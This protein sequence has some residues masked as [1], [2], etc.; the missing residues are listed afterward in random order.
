MTAGS[1]RNGVVPTVSRIIAS[2]SHAGV[3]Q[4]RRPRATSRQFVRPSRTSSDDRLIE[5]GLNVR[6]GRRRGVHGRWAAGEASAGAGSLTRGA[7]V[8][9][10]PSASRNRLDSFIVSSRNASYVVTTTSFAS[11]G[12]HVATHRSAASLS[13]HRVSGSSATYEQLRWYL[14]LRRHVSESR[15]PSMVRAASKSRAE[16]QASPRSRWR[17]N[18]GDTSALTDRHFFIAS[19]VRTL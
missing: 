18:G 17:N 9:S 19:K 8:V 11:H 14:L 1:Q 2:R 13:A 10:R 7:V 15:Q 4:R 5:A 3:L 6:T 16:S 12:V